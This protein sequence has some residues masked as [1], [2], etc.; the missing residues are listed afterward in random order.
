MNGVY[1]YPADLIRCRVNEI[2]IEETSSTLVELNR[3]MAGFTQYY[4]VVNQT[5]NQILRMSLKDFADISMREGKG[6]R[7]MKASVRDYLDRSFKQDSK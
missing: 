7:I 3:M 1:L 4:K 5:K 6:A 2:R